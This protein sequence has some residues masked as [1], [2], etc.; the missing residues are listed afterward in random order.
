MT[1]KFALDRRQLALGFATIGATLVLP[2]IAVA[3]VAPA[4]S[5]TPTGLSLKQAATLDVVAELIIPATD[6]PGA[7]EAGVPQFVDRAIANYCTPPNA[8]AIREGLDRM[9]ADAQGRYGVSFVSLKPDQQITL[10]SVYDSEV[11]PAAT[12]S[13]PAKAL[14][15]PVLKDLVT[16]GYF[17]SQQGATKAVRWDPVPGAYRGCVPLSEI[18]RAWAI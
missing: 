8:L 10:L 3:Q 1:D 4:L 7:R 15:F 2:G 9:E 17:T 5:W 16:V 18:G 13:A 11:A 6:T 14:F 12:Q